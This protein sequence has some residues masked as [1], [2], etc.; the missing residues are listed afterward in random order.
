ML[1]LYVILVVSCILSGTYLCGL[2]FYCR[3]T[4][5]LDVRK[6]T[7]YKI[8]QLVHWCTWSFSKWR[9]IVCPNQARF[10]KCLF[11]MWLFM[12]R[13]ESSVAVQAIL[14]SWKAWNLLHSSYSRISDFLQGGISFM[15]GT[16]AKENAQNFKVQMC[17]VTAFRATSPHNCYGF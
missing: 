6:K 4:E 11:I 2:Y 8:F 13:N 12:C 7:Q 9:P 5:K 15:L 3:I 14:W 17:K 16:R 1:Y 10:H